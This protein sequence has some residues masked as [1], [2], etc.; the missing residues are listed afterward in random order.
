MASG[1]NA[2]F[3]VEAT[4]LNLQFQWQ[5][6]GKTLDPQARY[7]IDNN[8]TNSSILRIQPVKK[9]DKGR[10]KCLVINPENSKKRKLSSEAELEV[11]K[12]L[13]SG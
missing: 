4:G 11:C 9:N 3:L 2:E 10:Y 5:K 12:F 6:F 1:A 13:V 7:Y 8:Q